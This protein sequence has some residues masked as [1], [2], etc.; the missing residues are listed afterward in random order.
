L[1]G[2][3]VNK[4]FVIVL[5]IILV[6]VL[7]ACGGNGSGKS[8]G[9]NA[10][11]P[12]KTPESETVPE[13]ESGIYILFA[14]GTMQQ[15]VGEKGGEDA[16]GFFFNYYFSIY[17]CQTDPKSPPGAGA[18]E[19]AAKLSS[20]SDFNDSI[21]GMLEGLGADMPVS[22]DF[23]MSSEAWGRSLMFDLHKDDSDSEAELSTYFEPI[24]EG[25][26]QFNIAASAGGYGS[27]QNH[28]TEGACPLPITV[29]VFGDP[30]DSVRPALITLILCEGENILQFEGTLSRVPWSGNGKYADSDEFKDKIANVLGG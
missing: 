20:E 21:A 12:S 2:L 8:G 25:G 18:Y 3:E 24:F 6:F 15:D 1:E 14:E 22:V 23:D 30:Q 13:E 11:G 7:A 10:N 16:Q 19:G 5:V 26:R 28:D 29:E 9:N 17:A 27:S 4:V